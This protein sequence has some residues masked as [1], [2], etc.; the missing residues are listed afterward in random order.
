MAGE[1]PFHGQ[2]SADDCSPFQNGLLPVLRAGGFMP[3]VAVAPE[4]SQW[5]VVRGQRL[6]VQGDEARQE[7]ARQEPEREEGIAHGR[8]MALV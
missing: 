2:E 1:E 3:A 6:L 5:P 4:V 7:A 8:R